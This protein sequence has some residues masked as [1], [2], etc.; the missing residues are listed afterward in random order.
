MVD[1]PGFIDL[2]AV[3]VQTGIS[4][5]AA[6]K[7]V[8]IDFKKLNPDLTY[9]MLRIIRKSELTGLSQALQDLSISL[10]TTE[11]RMFCTVLQQ[12]LN[13]GSSIYSHL[14]QLSADIRE[15]QLL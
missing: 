15:I 3:N 8:A 13:F 14:I 5:D 4:I 2:V 9:V 12:S 10:P 11:I 7:Q 1:L 6:L